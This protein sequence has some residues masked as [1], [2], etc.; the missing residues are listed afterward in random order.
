MSVSF[1]VE[2]A[3][4]ASFA[5]MMAAFAVTPGPANVFMMATG[6][7][8]GA[9]AVPWAVL[10][11]NLATTVWYVAAAFGLIA[12]MSAFPLVFRVLSVGGGLYVLWLA[13]KM[14]WA[15][16]SPAPNSDPAAELAFE[17]EEEEPPKAE[18]DSVYAT[19]R[20]GFV[21]QIA[22][23]KAMVFFSGALPPFLNP[24]TD[25]LQQFAVF[26]GATLIMDSLAMGGYGLLAALAATTLK[27]PSF[28]RRFDFA[29]GL[30]LLLVAV[31]IL[32][33]ALS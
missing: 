15:A 31:L 9:R 8:Q 7:K 5:V 13:V 4:F 1:P 26:A 14:L 33:R 22:N 16:R 11:L 2:P 18:Q 10:G 28:R 23:P 30:L 17:T 24:Q 21:V 12:L 32:W 25:V 6:L 29:I 27:A 20:A 3:V 19:L